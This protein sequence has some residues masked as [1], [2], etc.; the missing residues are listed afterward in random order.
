MFSVLAS[1]LHPDIESATNARTRDRLLSTAAVSI[2]RFMPVSLCKK[3][4]WCLVTD[5]DAISS[6][7]GE[8]LSGIVTSH[9]SSG[10]SHYVMVCRLQTPRREMD[11][12]TR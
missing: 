1:V 6:P 5:R 11:S 12:S 7:V 3:G 8:K 10:T 9:R 2:E 4:D